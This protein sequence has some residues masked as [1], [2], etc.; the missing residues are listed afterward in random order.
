MKNVVLM[1]NFTKAVYRPENT[2][3]SKVPLFRR[4]KM[5]EYR[6]KVFFTPSRLAV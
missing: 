1:V 3:K 6:V 5:D 4:Q 2:V